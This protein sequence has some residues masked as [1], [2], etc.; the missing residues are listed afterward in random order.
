[1]AFGKLTEKMKKKSGELK[2]LGQEFGET[3]IEEFV[4][5]FNRTLPILEEAGFTLA[6]LAVDM[7][8]PPKLAPYFL[9]G[10]VPDEAGQAALLERNK[11][12]KRVKLML[13]T[14]FNAV[15]LQGNLKIDGM[16]P[17]GVEIE[18]STMPVTRLKFV[19]AHKAA[20]TKRQ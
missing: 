18:I 12:N 11:E 7:G 16:H 2:E 14:L 5:E 1:M 6:E 13:T 3:K 8:L 9:I 4:A 19:D 15:A 10:T 20:L 17:E